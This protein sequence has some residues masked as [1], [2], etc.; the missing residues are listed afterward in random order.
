MKKILNFIKMNSDYSVLFIL[1]AVGM[2]LELVASRLLSPY[3]GNSNFVWTAIIGIILLASSFGNIIGGKFTSLKNP[4]YWNGLLLIFA[5]VYIALIPLS[6]VPILTS[7]SDADMGVQLAAVISSIVF[8]LIPATILGIITPIIVKERV[9]DGKNKGKE[10]GCITATIAIGSLVGTFAGGFW[11]IPALGTKM[12]FV[13]LAL[14][15]LFTILL[16][17]PWS[18]DK[19]SNKLFIVIFLIALAVNVLAIATVCKAQDKDKISIDTEYGRIIIEKGDLDGEQILYYKQ[20]GA[21]TSATYLDEGRKYDL[22][23]DYLKKYD[24][25]F[26]ITDV[27]NVAMIGGAAYQYPKYFIS[28]FPDKKMDVIEIDPV[29]T[30]IAKKYFYLDDLLN[31]YGEDRLGLYTEDGRV[32][33]SGKEKAYDAILNDA[34]SGEVPVGSLATKEAATV[35]KKSLKPGGVYMSNILG[36]VHGDKGRFLRSEVK[37]LQSVFNKVYVLPVYKKASK[38]DY[39]NWMILATDNQ[40]YIPDKV[41]HVNLS[42]NDIVLT[43]DYNPIDEMISTNYHE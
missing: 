3:F 30:E 37:T 29:S 26:K 31:D 11:L 42:E 36:S 28:N 12:I 33:L 1:N 19:K 15:I 41:V 27:K 4:R 5:S 25:I 13:L 34:F 10:S 22:V 43:D 6:D 18:K 16:A 23:F 21:Y 24:E 39:I 9:G 35:I 14:T 17:K 2:I 8:F 38:T 40:E 20:S 32:F 7:I